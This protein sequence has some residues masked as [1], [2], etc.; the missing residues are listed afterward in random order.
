LLDWLPLDIPMIAPASAD[1]KQKGGAK[2]MG[3]RAGDFQLA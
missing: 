2:E 3:I 1:L